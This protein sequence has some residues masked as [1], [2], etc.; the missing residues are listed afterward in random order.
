[1]NFNFPPKDHILWYMKQSET[2]PCTQ[3][4]DIEIAI[5]GGGMAGLSAA[6]EFAKQG[7]KVAIFEQY[8][9]GSGASGKSS[10]LVTPNAELYLTDFANRFNLP[11]A[12][13]I[14]DMISSGV[15]KIS[16]NIADHNFNCDFQVQDAI[17]LATHKSALK[18]FQREHDNLSKIGYQSKLYDQNFVPSIINSNQYFGALQYFN[19]FSLNP[20]LYCQELKQHLESLGVLIFEQTPITNIFDHTLI[21]PHAKI[22]A[23]FIVVC[24]DKNFSDLNLLKG[25]VF[26]A[27]TFVM[28]SEQLSNDQIK[29][30]FPGNTLMAWDTQLIYN[31]F[32]MTKDNR[33]LLGGGDMFTTY[34]NNE[35]HNYHRI[36]KKLCTYFAQKFPQIDLQFEYQWSGLIGLSKD[37]APIIG[38]GQK[39][40]HIYYVTACTGLAIAAAL[41]TYS[42][43]HLLQGRN[44]L[45]A[46][47]SPYRKFPVSGLLQKIIGTR[48]SFMLSNIIKLN[49]P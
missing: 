37:I 36:T 15:K 30:I 33:L 32:R 46:Y 40:S 43:Q 3:N 21:T 8:F 34:A 1:M 45:D 26:H 38:R 5:V 18:T 9:C 31:Y 2:K 41:G 39:F 48:L 7:K 29:N 22:T 25:D 44:D 24:I 20:Y 14:W 17:V 47:F 23:D 27:Q 12:H 16:D 10:G 11:V 28:A 35:N 19:S 6:Q 4:L 13:Q 42:A 49:I